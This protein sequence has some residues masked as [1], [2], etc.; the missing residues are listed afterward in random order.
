[1]ENGMFSILTKIDIN[2]AYYEDVRGSL[3]FVISRAG[4]RGGATYKTGEKGR[5]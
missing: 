3:L 2:I 5:G 1:V 4:K